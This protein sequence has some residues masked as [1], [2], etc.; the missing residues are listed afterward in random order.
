M[1]RF[2]KSIA[3]EVRKGGYFSKRNAIALQQDL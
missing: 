2:K 1:Q 3:L